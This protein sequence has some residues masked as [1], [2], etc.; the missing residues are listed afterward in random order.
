MI[1]RCTG[2]YCSVVRVSL[3]TTI[4]NNLII[5]KR[6]LVGDNIPKNFFQQDSARPHITRM[7]LAK[8]EKLGWRKI[9]QPPYSPDIASSDY[10][11]LRWLEYFLRGKRFT[12]DGQIQAALEDFFKSKPKKFK[13]VG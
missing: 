2:S 1:V 10:H 11:L 9:N 12:E 5:F 6:K 13:G 7:T 4:V 3:P 8:T